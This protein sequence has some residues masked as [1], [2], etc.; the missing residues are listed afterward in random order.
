[1]KIILT[2][3]SDSIEANIDPRFGR[4]AYF[5]EIDTQNLDLTAHPNPAAGSGGGAG[6]RAAQFVSEKSP[7][8][9]ISGN[10][11]PNAFQTIQ[12]AGIPMYLYGTCQTIRQAIDSF[13]AG[14]LEKIGSASLNEGYHNHG[15]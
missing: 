7:D 6:V 12:A 5:L 15:R 10:F 14:E 4:A 1:M 9:V 13:N 3:S 8:A 11:G 2:S